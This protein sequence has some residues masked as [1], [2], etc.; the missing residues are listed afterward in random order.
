MQVIPAVLQVAAV[1]AKTAAVVGMKMAPHI[2]TLSAIAGSAATLQESELQRRQ[3]DL[4]LRAEKINEA[5]ERVTVNE[6]LL[7]LLSRNTVAAVTSG[8]RGEGSVQRAQEAA[9]AVAAEQ[10]SLSAFQRRMQIMGLQQQRGV[11]R[12]RAFTE[13]GIG[14]FRAIEQRRQLSLLERK[15][16]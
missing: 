4:Q 5:A 15:I 7:E 13:A 6:E 3:I 1:G 8:L 10:L 14:L 12:T 2:A 11:L 16:D 9:Q